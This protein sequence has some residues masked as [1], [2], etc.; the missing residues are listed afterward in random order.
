MQNFGRGRS[1]PAHPH[2]AGNKGL[3]PGAGPGAGAGGGSGEAPF[4]YVTMSPFAA[5]PPIGPDERDRPPPRSLDD[6]V[7]TSLRN[8]FF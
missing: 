8:E 4:T 7:C 1:P 3:G 2:H 5:L 6:T